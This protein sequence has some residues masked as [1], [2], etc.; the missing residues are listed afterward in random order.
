MAE[1]SA[2]FEIVLGKRQI[3]GVM[4]VASVLLA[5]FSAVS[6]IAGEAVSPRK[7]S[8]IERPAPG[9][10]V[11]PAPAPVVI[12]APKPAA[13]PAPLFAEP[14]RGGLYLQM[15]A[16]DKGMAAILAEGLRTH[17]FDAFVAP[18][19]SEKIF[20]VLIGPLAD[21]QAYR[22]V[23]DS[24]DDLGLNAFAKKIEQ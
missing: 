10:T 23:K 16:L 14:A 12:E 8:A 19:P 6:Y 20:R 2:E 18:G 1:V 24:I 11:P 5:V 22:R 13:P 21:P 3:A 7:A 9:A 4:F 15:G 17:G